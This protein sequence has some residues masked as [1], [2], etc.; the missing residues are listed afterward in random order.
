MDKVW[1]TRRHRTKNVEDEERK[2]ICI[3]NTFFFYYIRVYAIIRLMVV[4]I[5]ITIQYTVNASK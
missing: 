2:K 1:K 4:F 3:E 5:T